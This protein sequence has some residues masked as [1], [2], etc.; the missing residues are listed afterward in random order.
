MAAAFDLV[1]S[2]G[3]PRGRAESA[4]AIRSIFEKQLVAEVAERYLAVG[5][6]TV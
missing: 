5:S 2:A 6:A 4:L 3:S 1:D